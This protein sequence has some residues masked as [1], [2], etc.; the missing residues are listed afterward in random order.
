[1]K[2]YI[3][4]KHTFPNGKVYIG[5]TSKNTAE[6]RWKKGRGYL[7]QEKMAKAIKEFGWDNIKHEILLSD[8]PEEK[9]TQIE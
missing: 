3:L 2:K 9:I 8:I 5:I 1:M 6:L 7:T 4:Y